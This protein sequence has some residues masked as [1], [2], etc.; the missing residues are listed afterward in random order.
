VQSAEIVFGVVAFLHKI[1]QGKKNPQIIDNRI[2]ELY[3]KDGCVVGL[4]RG[5][6]VGLFGYISTD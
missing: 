6:L 3:H 4:V 2:P 1:V 5:F